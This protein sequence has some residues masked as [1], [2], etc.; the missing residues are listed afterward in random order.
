MEFLA[1][2]AA[3]ASIAGTIFSVSAASANSA[4]AQQ[5]YQLQLK[6]EKE[7]QQ[8]MELQAHRQQLEIV[9]NQQRVQS[10]SVARGV[11]Q[12]AQFGSGLPGALGQIAGQG[13]TQE[14]GLSQNLQIGRSLFGINS[15]ISMLRGQQAALGSYYAFGMG[16]NS[17]GKDLYQ[18]SPSIYKLYQ[19]Y[20]APSPTNSPT[21]SG[22]SSFD[23]TGF[24]V[25]YNE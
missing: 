19:D 16:L 14:L 17:L 15:Q 5:E 4:I 20:Y 7:R 13:G 6:A 2:G 8:Q 9:R 21:P 12:N 3:I 25:A 11:N 18:A 22:T 23:E 24:Q 10:L 1:A